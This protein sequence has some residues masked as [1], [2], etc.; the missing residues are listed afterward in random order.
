MFRTFLFEPPPFVSEVIDDI[1][2]MRGICFLDCVFIY[3]LVGLPEQ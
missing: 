1:D 2:Y 3:Y